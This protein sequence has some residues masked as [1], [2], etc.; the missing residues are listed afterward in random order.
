MLIQVVLMLGV[1]SWTQFD[2]IEL[3]GGED[4]DGEP[5]T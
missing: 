3:L 2:G 5:I 4:C 1:L